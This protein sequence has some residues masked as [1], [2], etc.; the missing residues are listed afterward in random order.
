MTEDVS[1]VT[2]PWARRVVEGEEV[3]M[4]RFCECAGLAEVA[5]VGCFEAET[6]ERVAFGEGEGAGVSLC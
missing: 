4:G 6:G 5:E 2:V 3:E 1:R